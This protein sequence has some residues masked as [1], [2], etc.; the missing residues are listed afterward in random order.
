MDR[1]D[2]YLTGIKDSARLHASVSKFSVGCHTRVIKFSV[3]CHKLIVIA[4]IPA[5][6]YVFL[7]TWVL[8]DHDV[9]DHCSFYPSMFCY[10]KLMPEN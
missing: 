5:R 7:L 10:T 6:S 3:G 9:S 8:D 2:I 1:V 4:S